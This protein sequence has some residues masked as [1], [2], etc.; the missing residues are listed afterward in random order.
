MFLIQL[1][2]WQFARIEAGKKDIMLLK[3]ISQDTGEFIEI[4]LHYY[5]DSVDAWTSKDKSVG[6]KINISDIHEEF[7]DTLDMKGIKP[8]EV[9]DMLKSFLT[10][11]VQDT[12]SETKALSAF[13]SDDIVFYRGIKH[14]FVDYCDDDEGFCIILNEINKHKEKAPLDDINRNP[15]KEEESE[16]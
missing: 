4:Q 9:L 10:I 7:K 2:D 3:G 5:I 13:E 16:A 6:Y 1:Q 8:E 12:E 11:N 14:K 15:P